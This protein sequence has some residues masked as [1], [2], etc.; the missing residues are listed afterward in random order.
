MV[1]RPVLVAILALL[2]P[3]TAAFGQVNATVAGTVADA[4]GALIPG[5]EVTATNVN[6]GIVTSSVTNET[7]SYNFASLQPGTYK[8]SAALA[9]FKTQT[10]DNVLLSQGQQVRLN[11]NLEVAAVGDTVEVT[12]SADATLATTSASVG[13]V[14]PVQ[15]VQSLPLAVRD[16][17][18]LISATAGVSGGRNFGGQGSRALNMTRDGL[19]VNDTR[20]G[21]GSNTSGQNG[22]FVSSDLVEEVQVVVGN[23]DAESGRGSGQVSLQTRSGTN[24]FHGAAFYFNNNSALNSNDFFQNLTGQKKTYSN[25]NQY[26]GRLGGPIVKNKAFFFVL[27]DNQRYL[28]KQNFVASVLT[29][30]ARQGIFRYISGQQNGNALSAQ[31]S[32][33]L[34]GN[35]LNPSALRSFNLF[36]DVGDPFRTGISK[37]AYWQY[38]LSKMPLP[39]DYTVGDGLNVAGYRWLRPIQGLGGGNSVGNEN[40]RDQLNVRLDYQLNTKNKLTFTT[41]REED[42]GVTTNLL[43]DWPGGFNGTNQYFPHLYTVGWTSTLSNTI[44]NEFRFG[45]KETSYHR[46]APFQLG[47]CFDDD[48]SSWAD[49]SPEAKK[50]YDLLPKVGNY[51]LF[52]IGSNTVFRATQT[53]AN[54][55]DQGPIK[56]GF[57]LTRGQKSPT[58]QISDNL[59][60]TQGHHSYKTGFEIIKNWSNGW[61]TTSEQIPTALLGQGNNPVTNITST[62]FAGLNSNDATAAVNILNDLAGSINGLTFGRVI[63]SPT[64]TTWDDFAGDPRRFR[65]LT[66]QDWAAFFKDT[67]NV[68]SNLTLNLGLR[69]DKFG[70]LY[71]QKGMIARAKGGEKALYN[72]ITNGTLT[73]S[74]FVGKNSPNPK[75]LFWPNDWNNLGPSMGFSYKMPWFGRTT[76]LRGGYGINYA[77]A[78]VILDYENDFGNSP[79]SADVYL[80]A[81]PFVPAGYLNLETA[82]SNKVIPLAPKTQPGIIVIPLTDKTQVMNTPTDNHVTPYIQNFNMSLQHELGAGLNLELAYVGSK[83]TKLFQKRSINEPELFSNGILEAFNI[84]RAGGNAALFD[85]LLNGLSVPG[86]AGTVGQNLSGSDAFRR[87]SS[88][89]S[90]LANGSVAQFADFVSKTN[91]IT[92]VNGGLLTRAGLPQSFI[93]ASPQFSDAQI[94]GTGSNSSY[95]SM[96]AQ[97]T[98]RFARG[99]TGQFSYTWSKGLGDGVAGETG[100]T[101]LDPANRSRNKSRQSFDHT[102]VINAHG[103]WEIPVGTGKAFLASAPTWLD[104]VIGGWQ[105]SGIGTFSSG[106]PLNITSTARTLGTISNLSVPDIVGDFPKSLGK[107]TK[108]NQFVEYFPGIKASDVVLGPGTDASLAQFSTLRNIVDASG[109]VLLTN[110]QPGTVGTL[111][112]RWIEGPSQTQLDLS[113]AKKVAIME[114]ATFTLRID[115]I[116]AL[117]IT[118]WGNPNT[119]INDVNFGRI[120][121]LQTGATP[122][123]FTLSGRV[124]F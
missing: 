51:V 24:Q 32:V 79:G 109:R 84:T 102:H 12:T 86:V 90:F 104:R 59:S 47:C 70:V 80:P 46:R 11:F 120:T 64:Q 103:T 91:A 3:M 107:I 66:Q 21:T 122:R 16:V 25:R 18:G 56:Q 93:T 62:R 77:G 33:D 121:G 119:N 114:N 60:W 43:S 2:L 20:Y 52:P 113:L 28:Q 112:T 15:E 75:D 19:V 117:N 92:G 48:A 116:N 8:V 99:A 105:L 44:L 87:W 97:L 74:Q 31:P 38:V 13:D 37:D 50:A 71:D 81:T 40:N 72:Y 14:L 54:T 57:D 58:R 23:V 6:T 98:K 68:T 9:S 100:A 29:P 95:H 42:W 124:D 34:N 115:A 110:P 39:N 88:T 101:T 35:I 85:R 26:G 36:S 96:Q 49:R 61:N 106:D 78:T 123:Q 4:T 7:G 94:W 45:Y 69:Y 111:G 1:Q 55:G 17:L 27:V 82:V 73:E 41:S 83:G 89:R 10:Y 5:V 118:P 76:V 108:G 63:N 67:W 65:H 53:G 22:T 30:E